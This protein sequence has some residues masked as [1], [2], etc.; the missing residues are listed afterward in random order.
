MRS[1]SSEGSRR[2]VSTT[3]TADLSF[4]ATPLLK[5]DKHNGPYNGPYAQPSY[6]CIQPIIRIYACQY[7]VL[8]LF[9]LFLPADITGTE[10]SRARNA[11]RRSLHTPAGV[12]GQYRP[13]TRMRKRYRLTFTPERPAAAPRLLLPLHSY[14]MSSHEILSECRP[15]ILVFTS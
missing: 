11:A 3:L 1:Q 14:R 4:P 12:H 5:A 9:F 13:F 15:Y 7:P 2:A 6:V 8:L 10:K